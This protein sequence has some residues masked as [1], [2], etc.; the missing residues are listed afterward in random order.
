MKIIIAA[1]IFAIIF[2]SWNTIQSLIVSVFNRKAV[3]STLINISG[4]AWF[5]S[6]VLINIVLLCFTTWFYFEKKNT[7]GNIGKKGFPG[8]AGEDALPN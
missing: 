5:W 2:Y 8:P 6:L 7:P 1:V 4:Y 3:N